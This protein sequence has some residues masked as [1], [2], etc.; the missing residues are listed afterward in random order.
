M[1]IHIGKENTMTRKTGRR[2]KKKGRGPARKIIKHL[3]RKAVLHF[4]DMS[5]SNVKNLNQYQWFWG[6]SLAKVLRAQLAKRI[7]IAIGF[8][9]SN[10]MGKVYPQYV[11]NCSAEQ[12]C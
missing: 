6:G 12:C 3:F 4:E 9:K 11:V 10:R 7:P 1:W 2:K 5:K 8:W